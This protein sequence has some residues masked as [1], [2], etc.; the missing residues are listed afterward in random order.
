MKQKQ[1]NLASMRR[2]YQQ[3]AL[4]TSTAAPNAIDQFAKWFSET[5]DRQVLEPNAFILA[6]CTLDGKP[7]ARVLLLKGFDEK[8]F[9]FYSNYNS[10]KGKELALNPQAAMVFNWL[11]AERQVRIEGLVRKV[12][13]EESLDYFQSRP[14]GSQIG[15]WASPQS[16]IIQ[17]REEIDTRIRNLQETYP[18]GTAIPLP[19][20][21]GGFRLIPRSIEFWQGRSNRL[22]DRLRYTQQSDQ[23]WT[24]ERLAP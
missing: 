2:D 17:S 8:G 22:H 6:T 12:S 15:A 11:E 4:D 9:V 14:H 21:W 19:D 13:A 3:D 23:S 5:V 24:I 18:E 16:K 7:S 10:Q 20:H 1:P